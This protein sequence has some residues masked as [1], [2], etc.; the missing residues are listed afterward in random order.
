[1]EEANLSDALIALLLIAAI[2]TITPGPATMIAAATGARFGFR[3]SLP[4]MFGTATGLALLMV[5][6]AAGLAALLHA[7]PVAQSAMKA[8]GSAYLVWLAWRIA[9]SGAPDIGANAA[10]SPVG[11]ETAIMVLMLN[12]KAW[13]MALGARA[14]F[15]GLASGPAQLGALLGAVFGIAAIL[16]LSVWCFSG[17]LIGRIL[18]TPGQW[19]VVNGVFAV[20]TVAAVVPLWR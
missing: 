7:A 10:V 20:L 17:I 3:R 11:F 5:A 2:T 12:P 18:R 1:M 19:Q 9:R 8:T 15:A 14:A 16:S 6:A 13:I 4:L